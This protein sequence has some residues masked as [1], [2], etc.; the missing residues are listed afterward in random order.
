MQSCPT[1]LVLQEALQCDELSDISQGENVKMTSNSPY[2]CENWRKDVV[3]PILYCQAWQLCIASEDATEV[4]RL[5]HSGLMREGG[6]GFLR[7]FEHW[8]A[9]VGAVSRRLSGPV[10]FHILATTCSRRCFVY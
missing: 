7:M 6:R 10:T 5:L 8:K 3:T 4:I 2:E 9:E 1:T